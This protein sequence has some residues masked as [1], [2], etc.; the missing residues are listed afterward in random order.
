MVQITENKIDSFLSSGKP[1]EWLSHLPVEYDEVQKTNIEK[2]FRLAIEL[3]YQ[4]KESSHERETCLSLKEGLALADILIHLKV[5]AETLSAAILFPFYQKHQIEKRVLIDKT[6][7]MIA[8]LCEGVSDMQAINAFQRKK[9]DNVKQHHDSQQIEN[10]RKMLLAMV[11]DVRLVLLKLAERLYLLREAKH[12]SDE[13]RCEV[14]KE[15]SDIYAPLA[16]RLGLGQIKWEMEDLSFRY[17]EPKQY[18]LIASSLDERRIDRDKFVKKVL[19]IVNEQ[20]TNAHIKASVAGRAKHIYSIWRKMERKKVPFEEIYDIRA[21]RILV[22]KIPDCYAILGIVH[23]LWQHIPKEFDDYIATPKENGYRS[24]HTAV[25]G[26]EGKVLEIQIRTHEMHEESELGIAAHWRYK[27]GRRDKKAFFEDKIDW[28][29]Q[30]IEWQEEVADEN[31]IMEDFRNEFVDDRIYVFTPQGKVIDLP[32]E[33]TPLDFAYHVHTDIGH[34]CRGA[35]VNGRISA[36]T[37]PLKTGDQIEVLTAKN[38]TP[39]RDWLNHHDGYVKSSRAR[40]KIHQWFKLQDKDKNIDLGKTTLHKE[41]EQS[42]LSKVDLG[43]IAEKFNLHSIDDLYAAVGSGDLGLHLISNA[44]KQNTQPENFDESDVV[45]RLKKQAKKE[46]QDITIH[47]VDNLLTNIAGCCKPVPGESIIGYITQNRGVVIHEVNCYYVAVAKK[48]N[49]ERL[50]NVSW[51]DKTLDTYC[52]DLMIK[53]N[54]RKG[55]LK[56][57][58]TVLLNEKSNVDTCVTY[59]NKNSQTKTISIRIHIEHSKHLSRIIDKIIQLP[60]I[61]DVKRKK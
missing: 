43:K 57:I 25:I 19:N 8:R 52:V 36:L 26:P 49:P 11:D 51:G 39:S 28:L 22:N 2:A 12:F 30:L 37:Q 21:I 9:S 24:L 3:S 48:E 53:V 5:D 7:K 59:T 35:K 33:A 31:Q 60:N 13:E 4:E 42:L 50:V 6:S 29:R 1:D 34:K 23:S 41:I 58:T 38:G 55:I 27:E 15:V 56:D 40:R 44:I 17:L 61:I 18:K 20:I 14:A 10:L 32:I 47:G 46:G 45:K 16:N 54:D